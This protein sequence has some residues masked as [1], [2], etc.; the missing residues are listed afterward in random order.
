MRSLFVTVSLSTAAEAVRHA[1]FPEHWQL[2]E[3]SNRK[4]S[5]ARVNETIPG[6]TQNNI[7][8]VQQVLS[9]YQI[10][11][12]GLDLHE[13]KKVACEQMNSGNAYMLAELSAELFSVK[14]DPNNTCEALLFAYAM[15]S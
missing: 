8:L 9:K 3:E 14:S 6:L 7:G 2:Q 1:N 11:T 10:D 5:R 13:I 4:R 12:K 15:D